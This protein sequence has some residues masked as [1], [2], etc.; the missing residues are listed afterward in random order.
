MGSPWVLL[1]LGRRSSVAS[2]WP[3]GR[4][5]QRISGKALHDGGPKTTNS[6]GASSLIGPVFARGRRRRPPPP[7]RNSQRFP[8]ATPSGEADRPVAEVEEAPAPTRPMTRRRGPAPGAGSARFSPSSSCADRTLEVAQR[9]ATRGAPSAGRDRAVAGPPV[10]VPSGHDQLSLAEAKVC[11]SWG[12]GTSPCPAKAS[13]SFFRPSRTASTSARV[14][15]RAEEGERVL[16]A[17]LLAHEQERQVGRQQEQPAAESRCFAG[18]PSSVFS[19]SPRARLPTWSWFWRQTT[20]RSPERP[21]ADARAC[22][23]GTGC[24]PTRRRTASRAPGPVARAR[25]SQRSTRP[26]A[27]EERVRGM[28]E[29]VGPLGIQAVAAAVVRVEQTRVVQVALADHDRRPAPACRR[30]I[31]RHLDRPEGCAGH[32]GRRWRATASRRRPSKWNSS[33]HIR[34]LSST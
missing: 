33:S 8:P 3:A 9:P 32:S 26:L 4:R 28:M 34:T 30:L 14:A 16:L 31:G 21:S 25:R 1:S 27:G 2:W 12:S 18:E 20:K 17:V 13:N 6:N 19:R 11:S 22:G 29:V 5:P 23:R 7:N 10:G 24:S 15:E